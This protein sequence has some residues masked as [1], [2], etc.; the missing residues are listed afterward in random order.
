MK[1]HIALLALAAAVSTPVLA[2]DADWY[3]G[4]DLNRTKFSVDGESESKTGLGLF[5][6]YNLSKAVAFEA[7]YARLGTW[8]EDGVRIEVNTLNASVLGKAA[9]A[10]DLVLFGRLGVARNTVEAGMGNLKASE[11]KTKALIGVGLDYALTPKMGLRAEYV[12]LG[13][14][15]IDFASVKMRQLNLGLTYAF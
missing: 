10:D 2:A 11:H 15:K 4:A 13:N 7:K 12:N 6:G 5:L 9:V 1:K 3:L 14:N 8:R